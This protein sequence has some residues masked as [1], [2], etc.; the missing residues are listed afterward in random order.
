VQITKEFQ[1]IEVKAALVSNAPYQVVLEG[2]QL[3]WGKKSFLTL[4]AET[5]KRYDILM[6][7]NLVGRILVCSFENRELPLKETG[8]FKGSVDMDSKSDND[9]KIQSIRKNEAV[10][11]S[12]L[13]MSKHEQV[14]RIAELE[15]FR[16]GGRDNPSPLPYYYL[17]LELTNE[18]YEACK[19][20][21]VNSALKVSFRLKP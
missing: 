20:L 5:L 15:S 8:H 3:S 18:E 16:G 7:L 10:L 6:S 11:P 13:T 9:L 2:N 1:I 19:A 14:L 4:D 17:V 12:F 21:P